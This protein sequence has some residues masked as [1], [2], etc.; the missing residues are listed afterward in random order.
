M[1]KKFTWINATITLD[2]PDDTPYP[3]DDFDSYDEWYNT[4]VEPVM[5]KLFKAM[6]S[7]DKN[8]DVDIQDQDYEI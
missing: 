2:L 5:D 6:D 4:Y 3:P 1:S 7:I 8:V